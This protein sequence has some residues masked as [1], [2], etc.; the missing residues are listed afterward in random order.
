ME[1]CRFTKQN[2]LFIRMGITD[3][4]ITRLK[5]HAL[6]TVLDAEAIS[7][8]VTDCRLGLALA[9]KARGAAALRPRMV[10]HTRGRWKLAAEA[11]LLLSG[12]VLSR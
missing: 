1:M 8:R 9:L 10:G 6:D 12:E 7:L 2:F 5:T 11:V 3:A 4:W